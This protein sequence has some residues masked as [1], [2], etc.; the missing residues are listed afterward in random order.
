MAVGLF[1]RNGVLVLWHVGQGPNRDLI[2]VPIQRPHM[3][4]PIVMAMSLNRRIVK[5]HVNVSV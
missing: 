4:V 2:C 5:V 1:G 3:E